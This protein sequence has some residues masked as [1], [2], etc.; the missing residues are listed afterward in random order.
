MSEGPK[1]SFR[2]FAHDMQSLPPF[3]EQ[4][5]KRKTV[6][7]GSL[8][9]LDLAVLRGEFDR[10]DALSTELQQQASVHSGK[11]AKLMGKL[12][13]GTTTTLKDLFSINEK[14][15][16]DKNASLT[17]MNR[18]QAAAAGAKD[19]YMVELDQMKLQLTVT[20]AALREKEGV[21]ATEQRRNSQM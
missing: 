16:S 5:T 17:E 10:Y 11:L 1:G 21:L 15:A 20:R 8:P 9:P 6:I 12:W 18:L 14:L 19:A 7:E 3:M 2:A 13:D 4:V